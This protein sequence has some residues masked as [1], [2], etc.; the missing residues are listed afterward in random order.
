[1]RRMRWVFLRPLRASPAYGSRR[2]RRLLLANPLG[3]SLHEPT[4][5]VRSQ[6]F[7]TVLQC[8]H[9][10]FFRRIVVARCS[11]GAQI[12]E[13]VGPVLSSLSM[14]RN[15]PVGDPVL[16]APISF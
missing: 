7:H 13:P 6:A 11:L 10:Q 16:D 5:I 8:L 15:E 9:V 2:P 12:F 4:E 1:M 3:N 14:L